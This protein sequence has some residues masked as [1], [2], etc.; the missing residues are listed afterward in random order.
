MIPLGNKIR[1]KELTS[2]PDIVVLQGDKD[3]SVVIMP[4][5]SYNEKLQEMINDGIANGKYQ[6]TSDNTIQ[7]LQIGR[8]SC[9]ERV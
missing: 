8:A 2:N 1:W 7:D 4:K 3:S 5:T 9:R 6:R